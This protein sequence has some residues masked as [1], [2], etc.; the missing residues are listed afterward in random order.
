MHANVTCLDH[1]EATPRAPWTMETLSSAT[2]VLGAKRFGDSCLQE[3]QGIFRKGEWAIRRQVG[4]VVVM[5]FIWVCLMFTC[6]ESI[7]PG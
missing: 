4:A 3:Q 5:E 2:P 1:R 7:F 6:V